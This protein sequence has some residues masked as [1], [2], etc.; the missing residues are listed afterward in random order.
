MK[1]GRKVTNYDITLNDKDIAILIECIQKAK[2]DNFRHQN[3]ADAL[4]E[5]FVKIFLDDNYEKYVGRYLELV[6][7]YLKHNHKIEDNKIE[8][9]IIKTKEDIKDDKNYV[10]HFDPVDWAKRLADGFEQQSNDGDAPI[11]L[12]LDR[13]TVAEG[14]Y[15]DKIREELLRKPSVG[16]IERNKRAQE[17]LKKLR[18]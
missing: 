2:L 1:V 7:I 14:E 8:K 3:H 11:R 12:S 6:G 16:A 10:F 13:E 15:A 18:R 5:E 4:L 17:L 9:L